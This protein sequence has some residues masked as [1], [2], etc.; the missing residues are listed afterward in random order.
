[1]ARRR[2]GRPRGDAVRRNPAVAGRTNHSPDD[3]RPTDALA[4]NG[5]V[6]Y[7]DY[8]IKTSGYGTGATASVLGTQKAE[9][10]IPDFNLGLTLKP[11]PNGSVE[12][13]ALDD[14]FS[15]GARLRPDAAFRKHRRDIEALLPATAR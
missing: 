9:F 7:D 11:L 12:R 4:L 6:R 13:K 1:M 5:G 3:W 15:E 14:H 10:G 8:S 2:V